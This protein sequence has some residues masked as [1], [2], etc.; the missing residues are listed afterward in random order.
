MVNFKIYDPINEKYRE[1]IL[2]GPNGRWY[3][4]SRGA[5]VDDGTYYIEEMEQNQI[6]SFIVMEIKE[7]LTYVE[8]TDGE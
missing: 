3:L 6:A 7:E 8:S 5:F 4:I 1:D 2:I